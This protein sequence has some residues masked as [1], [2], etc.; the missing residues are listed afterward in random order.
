MTYLDRVARHGRAQRAEPRVRPG[1]RSPRSSST[2]RSPRSRP[3]S[4]TAGSAR[5]RA[6][7]TPRTWPAAARCWRWPGPGDIAAHPARPDQDAGLPVGP[8]RRGRHALDGQHGHPE[9]L[10]EQARWRR[11]WIDF[12]YDPK[13]AAMIEAY[14]NY[15]CPVEGAARRDADDRPDLANNPL[16]FPPADWLARLHQFRST[17]RP[18]R[19]SP[20]PRPSPR[21]RA[22]RDRRCAARSASG[23]I[24][25]VRAAGARP[26]L[27]GDLLHLPGDPDVPG[28]AVDRQRPGRVPADVELGHLPGGVPASTGRGSPARSCTAA[29]RRSSP[30]R[31]ASRSPTPS[32]SAAA[33]YKNLLLFLVIAPFFTSFL[34]R[35]MSLEDHLLGRRDRPRSAQGPSASSRPTSSCWPRRPRSSP[36]S[37]TTSCRS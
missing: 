19:T 23:T 14:V 17:R 11:H 8:R 32:R 5:S 27:P 10:A 26:A 24:A 28:L 21:P 31:S 25:P 37:P 16:I 4:R 29:S 33:R 9:G 35:T 12:Y 3:P 7:R 36:A 20:G 22:S 18:R 34:L 13:N 1:E 6:T 2:R 15:V 30:S